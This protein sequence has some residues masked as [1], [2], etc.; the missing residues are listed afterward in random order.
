MKIVFYILAAGSLMGCVTPPT[1]V[2]LNHP[3]NPHAEGSANRRPVFDLNG[4]P[5]QTHEAA[6]GPS[7]HA[8]HEHPKSHE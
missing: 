5:G 3:A 2:A 4:S 8:E 7:E 1:P 6:T